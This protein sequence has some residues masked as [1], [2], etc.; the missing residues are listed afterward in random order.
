MTTS[1]IHPATQYA[2]DVVE[3]RRV[4]GRYE[5]LACQ[6]HLDDLAKQGSRGFMWEFDEEKANRVYRFFTYL[7][8]VKGPLAK[9]PIELEEFQKFDI[10]MIFGWVDKKKRTRRFHKAYKQEGRKNGKS[11]EAAGIALYLLVGDDE[12][13]PDVYSAAVDKNQAKIIYKD[14]KRMAEKS[15]DIRKR[16][17]IHKGEIS[18]KERGGEF[19]PFSKDSE[20]KD[21]FNPHGA[22]LDEY[23]AH[24]VSD[25]HDV[26]WSAWGQ[27]AQALFFII[28]TA[29]FN[30]GKSPCWHEYK[31]CKDILEQI[32]AGK[33]VG[34]RY[35]IMIREL[36]PDDNEHD[37]KNWIKANPLRCLTKEG[38]KF[39]KEQHDE[40]FQSKNPTKVR[41]F[42]IK[43]LDQWILGNED[44][45]MGELMAKWDNLCVIKEG[46]PKKKRDAFAKLTKGMSCSFGLDLS[47]CIDLTADGF[48]FVLE[49]GRV[50]VCAYGFMPEASVD[51][52]EKTDNVPYREFAQDGWMTITD[53]EIT[54]YHEVETH[55]KQMEIDNE[56]VITEQDFDP[57]N[58]THYAMEQK[59]AGYEVVEVRQGIP[60]LGEPTK[61][62]RDLVVAGKLVHDGSPML[63]MCVANAVVKSDSNGNI[64]VLK[65]TENSP[66]RIDLLAA[67]LNAMVALPRLK[68]RAPQDISDDILSEEYG[69]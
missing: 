1:S 13:S 52:H 23:H 31:E 51:A 58:A 20:N 64:K 30:A 61:V 29:G 46:T 63:R 55:M 6:R 26:I 69:F 47:K 2:L 25:V 34:D 59:A 53:G 5:K 41:N 40:A 24:K 17:N 43:N 3:G 11:T 67:I 54:D 28:T 12:E 7:R 42:R 37:S 14:A 8:H 45:Y 27:R 35:F 15:P 50:A 4:A 36:D 32:A 68:E 38:I 44:S 10:G 22:F 57:W 9:Q 65:P 60:T 18:H 16:L 62:F 66:E 21:G 48:V 33:K 49:D 19:K 39:L 56:W